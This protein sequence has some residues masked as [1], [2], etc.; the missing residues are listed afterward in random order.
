MTK[1]HRDKLINLARQ[2]EEIDQ[3][4]QRQ[5]LR[6]SSN[7]DNADEVDLD[8]DDISELTGLSRE[9]SETLIDVMFD[10]GIL[11]TLLYDEGIMG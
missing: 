3:N 1:E 5:M 4:E 8:Y 11:E 2:R 10:M 7:M 9:D 6:V